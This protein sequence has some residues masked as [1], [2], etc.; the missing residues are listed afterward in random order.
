MLCP[1]CR[2]LTTRGAAACDFCGAALG[3][4][5][6]PFNLVLSDG[7]R[8]PLAED[9]TIGRGADNRLRLDDPSVSRHHAR[10]SAGARGPLLRDGGSRHGAWLAGTRLDGAKVQLRDGSKI[11]VGDQTLR[12]E[13]HRS[14]AE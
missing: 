9:L 4:G 10:I 13:R 1:R 7:T 5:S 6:A 2:R 11:R 8:L 14:D 12:L 3:G